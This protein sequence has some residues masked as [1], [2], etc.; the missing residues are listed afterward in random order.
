MPPRVRL[1][2]HGDLH[3]RLYAVHAF[4]GFSEAW[5]RLHVPAEPHGYDGAVAGYIEELHALGF[6]TLSS[7]QG[8]WLPSECTA[9][10]RGADAIEVDGVR[11]TRVAPHLFI[12][13]GPGHGGGGVARGVRAL[14]RLGIDTALAER[15]AER[16]DA[17]SPQVCA[18]E[19]DT[20]VNLEPARALTDTEAAAWWHALMI[21]ARMPW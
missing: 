2:R 19:F 1:G 8:G 17:Y 21:Q 9:S 4:P 12:A 15:I 16:F 7:C 11:W 10:W 5:S 14:R 18:N 20:Y 13:A 6:G 3:Q